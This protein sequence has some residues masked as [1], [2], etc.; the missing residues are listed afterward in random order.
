MF[1]GIHYITLRTPTFDACRALYADRL[2]LREIAH[3][4]RPDGHRLSI[5]QVGPTSLELHEDPTAEPARDPA[6]GKTVNSMFDHHAWVNHF[7]FAMRDA[8]AVY[9]QLAARGIPWGFK[10]ADQPIGLHLV[11]R[12][13]LEI[14]SPAGL[15]LQ[16]AEIIDDQGQPVASAAPSAADEPWIGG[17][18]I[19]H[20]N[21]R[22]LDMPA[23][24]RFY[25]EVLGLSA[26][27]IRPT[28]IGEQ[29]DLDIGVSVIELA[30]Q[31]DFAAP[32]R[33]GAIAG[34]G[35]LTPDLAHT[36]AELRARG[37]AC[38][39]PALVE[40]LPG[41]ARRVLDFQDPDGLPLSA[42]TPI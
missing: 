25:T 24:R 28:R 6:T 3:G 14:A 16:F 42:V 26:T 36:A 4:R 5:F 8:F 20:I 40:L 41:I 33:A 37:V 29:C 30:W 18:R 10:P 31:P 11:R 17:D 38:A 9:D 21:I 12:R 1:T 19:D 27:P 15:L 22:A 32:L 7:A 35:L 39:A 34:L 13:L 23:K 2:R